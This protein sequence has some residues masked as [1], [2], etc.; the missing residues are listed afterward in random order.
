MNQIAEE[1]IEMQIDL[2]ERKSE[3]EQKE[4]QEKK[5]F[6][7]EIQEKE[8]LQGSTEAGSTLRS[9]VVVEHKETSEEKKDKDSNLI[10]FK[11]SQNEKEKEKENQLN[12]E[13]DKM[14]IDLSYQEDINKYFEN[15][16]PSEDYSMQNEYEINNPIN[17]ENNN[18]PN[19]INEPLN[20]INMNN[21]IGNIPN[22]NNNYNISVNYNHANFLQ[23]PNLIEQNLNQENNDEIL[24]G[25][26]PP[27]S[28]HFNSEPANIIDEDIFEDNYMRDDAENVFGNFFSNTK[29]FT[30]EIK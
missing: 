22:E 24:N 3:E 30:E 27:Q 11:E 23:N 29:P 1:N 26:Q 10:K 15:K 25:F 6:Y 4:I 19:Q 13:D 2:P 9:Q 17:Q 21:I 20:N 16:K 28:N 18:S 8:C 5:N 12:D 7:G 14:P